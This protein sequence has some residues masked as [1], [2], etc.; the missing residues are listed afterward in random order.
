MTVGHSSETLISDQRNQPI[1]T[2]LQH[3]TRKSEQDV[4]HRQLF[5]ADTL[6]DF[7]AKNVEE[8][9]EGVMETENSD[10]HEL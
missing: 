5:C 10:Q 1:T 7:E 9:D 2:S 3:D 6:L 8:E 4:I